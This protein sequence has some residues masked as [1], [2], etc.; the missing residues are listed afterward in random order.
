M[1]TSVASL[2]LPRDEELPALVAQAERAMALLSRELA[3]HRAGRATEASVAAAALA[4]APA[5]DPS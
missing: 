1:A 3:A 2:T 5:L 4:L